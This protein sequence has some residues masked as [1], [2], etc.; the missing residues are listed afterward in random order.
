K[1]PAMP[2]IAEDLGMMDDKVYKLLDAFGF[3]TMKV[4]QFA[5][6]EN[7]GENTYIL[8]NH[9]ENCLVFTGTHDN[10]TTVGWFKSLKR[11]EAKL[12]ADYVGAKV[13]KGNVH[14]VMHRLALMSVANLAIVP[15]QD[16]L[17]LDEAAIMNRP[18]TGT[19]N[20]AWRM[21]ADQWPAD[22]IEE[23]KSLNRIYGRWKEKETEAS[24]EEK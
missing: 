5:F 13:N 12:I 24:T 3:P 4:L 6:D 2:F 14:K 23:L 19:G 16:V 9:K 21:S 18:G 17:G 7:M 15:M 20:W 11:A 1:F 8:H 10:N 22:R